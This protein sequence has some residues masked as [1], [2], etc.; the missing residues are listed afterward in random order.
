MFLKVDNI[1]KLLNG[2]YDCEVANG[3][4]HLQ[5]T[6]RP[7]EYWVASEANSSYSIKEDTK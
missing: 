1:N 2:S 3:I 6:E 4:V 5:N 7:I